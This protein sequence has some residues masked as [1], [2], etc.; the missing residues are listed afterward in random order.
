MT[1][2]I[3]KGL[4]LYKVLYFYR[5]IVFIVLGGLLWASPLYCQNNVFSAQLI[6]DLNFSQIDGDEMAGFDRIGFGGG[7]GVSYSFVPRWTGHV[8]LMYRNVGARSSYFAPI[9]QSI[10]VHQAQ[11]PVYISYRTWWVNGLSK[12]HFDVGGL[13]GRNI[14]TKIN[15][16]RFEKNDKFIQDNIYSLLAGFGLWINHH[17]GIKTRYIRSFTWLMKNPEE[18]LAWNLYYISLQ[19]HYRF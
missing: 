9:K 14:H 15:F 4:F 5:N 6:T 2:T 16:P 11:I 18:D 7:V 12:F 17:H 1:P 10:D 8:E 19:Y 13:Y 3:K